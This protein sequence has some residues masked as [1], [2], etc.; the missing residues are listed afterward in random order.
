MSRHIF[1]QVLH[2]GIG[3]YPPEK[4]K[5]WYHYVGFM[6]EEQEPFDSTLGRNA[7]SI[8]IN[9]S[10]NV[11]PGLRI[12][13]ET[14]EINEVAQFLVH[15]EYAYGKLGCLPRVAP[16]SISFVSN[17]YSSSQLIQVIV[18]NDSFSL[19]RQTSFSTSSWSTLLQKTSCSRSR[20]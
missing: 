2:K 14:M 13:L 11:L 16:G 3:K 15:H 6:N 18:K 4:A 20:T 10:G 17:Q 9:G 12:A 8:I 1:V 19:Q 7:E 5:V